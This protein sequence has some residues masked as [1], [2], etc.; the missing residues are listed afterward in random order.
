MAKTKHKKKV[1]GLQY[2]FIKDD[3]WKTLLKDNKVDS[4]YKSKVKQINFFR[5]I[6]KPF[7]MLQIALFENKINKI[8][9]SEKQPVFILGHWRS[10][11]THMHYV[12]D[13]DP[14]FGTLTNYQ[15]FSFT[16]SLLSKR[17]VKFILAPLFPKER[18]QDNMK[19]SPN[20]PGEEEQPLSVVSTRTGIHSWI[21]TKNRSYFD[22]Y[23]LFK[24]ISKQEKEA[25][26]KDYM[27]VLKT[28]S[29]SNNEKQLLLKNP[30]NTSRVKELLELFP[31]AKFVFIHRHPLDVYISAVHLFAKVIE[32]QFLQY[33]TLSERK[34][35]IIYFFKTTLQKYLAERD[36]IPEGNLYEISYDEFTGNEMEITK[37]I[38]KKLGLGGFEEAQPHIKYYLDSVKKYERNKFR[39]LS[40]EVE[41]R[42]KKEWKFAFDE[43]NY[44]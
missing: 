35:M 3:I 12:F 34:E 23:N 11:T 26:Q 30:H 17:I 6:T 40:P 19:M 42:L 7:R 20:K 2:F 31:K 1:R 41:A 4:I 14:Q 22:K 5:F 37:D 8:D 38:Y 16:T 36:L 13:K 44:E 15:T 25:W 39:N 43:W 32:T 10:G 29:F 18:T 33:A 24:G 27:K 9:L 28:I 21:F